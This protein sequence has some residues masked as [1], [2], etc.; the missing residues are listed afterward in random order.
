MKNK[1]RGK[2]RT[3][4][5]DFGRRKKEEEV[6]RFTSQWL[7]DSEMK[8]ERFEDYYKAQ[9]IIE[10]DELDSF[11]SSMRLEL[12]VVFRINGRG[13][14]ANTLREKLETD[15]FQ[16][17]AKEGSIAPPRALPWYPEKLAW[18]F[19]FCRREL[20]RD[21][22][23]EA[24]HEYIKQ[25][26]A[27]GSISRQEA[28]SMIP[29]LVLDIHPNHRILDMCAAPGSKTAQLLEMLHN[30]SNSAPNGVVVAN[31]LDFKRCNMMTHQIRRMVS[32]NVLIT[33]SDAAY[34]PE[35]TK[36]SQQLLEFDRILVDVPCS[37]DGT[38]R[39]N[40]EIWRKWKLHNGVSLHPLQ[41]RIA[42]KAARLL[43]IGGLLAYS[44]CALNPIEDEAVVA[45][46]YRR[47]NGSLEIID[48]PSKLPDLVAKRGQRSW[49]VRDDSRYTPLGS[50]RS[51]LCYLEIIEHFKMC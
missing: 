7:Q 1:G 20:R 26:T 6:D 15:F 39:K 9:G 38:T 40:P 18:Q 51:L 17:L 48:L 3:L 34:F 21:S 5:R 43:A 22:N 42:M 11:L 14:F 41:L 45:E 37:G 47:C 36:F 12:P 46:L 30:D 50:M 16:K 28:V 27:N 29:P 23:F 32:P 25:E 33:S 10:D 35:R 4:N 8:N 49:I 2:R 13:P 31:D 24:L 44:T 19:D